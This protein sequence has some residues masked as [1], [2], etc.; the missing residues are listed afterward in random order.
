MKKFFAFQWHITDQ[1]DQRCKHCYIFS[2]G[3]RKIAEMSWQN[4]VKTL[5]NIIDMSARLNRQPYLY[6]TGGD[7]ILHPHFWE[8]LDLVRSKKIPFSILGNPFHIDDDLCRRL[9]SL[10][11]QKYQL[12]LD[13]LRDT[14]DRLRKNGS[15]D[16]TLEKINVIKSSDIRC[17]I[18]TTVSAENIDDIPQ[19]IDIVAERKVDVF[20]FARYCPVGND[21][22][23]K[24]SW[25][26]QPTDYRTFLDKCWQKFRQYKDSGT[27]FSLKDHLW[28]LYLYENGLWKIPDGLKDNVIYEGCHCAHSHFTI[29][30]DGRL[31]ACRR[32]E[33]HVGNINEKMY[34]VFTG[35]KMNYYRRYDQFEKCRKCELLRFC[36]G[37][38]AVAF[39]YSGDYYAPD[40]QCWKED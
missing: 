8:L 11:C 10:G 33:S 14:H 6:I 30:A 29:T 3:H 25:H 34:A 17:A 35:K 40:P 9:F 1:C 16:Q 23:K 36:R 38:P 4:L 18:M 13:G 22:A 28:M 20:S 15:F 27:T 39:G 37:C 21:N 12:S 5:D 2:D 19:L 24:T 7:P 32:F 26:I 31:M